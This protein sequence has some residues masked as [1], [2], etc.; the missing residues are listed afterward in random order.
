MTPTQ[1]ASDEPV[2]LLPCPFC[3]RA[4]QFRAALW[5]A[6]GDV[7]GIIH[8]EGSDLADPITGSILEPYPIEINIRLI[9][10]S[11]LQ[12]VERADYLIHRFHRWSAYCFLGDGAL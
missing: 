12:P 5:P 9:V 10:T 4:V 2:K 7:D 11:K 8:A 6:D 1:A 3:G